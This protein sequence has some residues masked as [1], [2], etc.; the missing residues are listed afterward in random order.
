MRLGEA[1]GYVPLLKAVAKHQSAL[2]SLLPLP[3][4]VQP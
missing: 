3:L 4:F 2:S 1:A